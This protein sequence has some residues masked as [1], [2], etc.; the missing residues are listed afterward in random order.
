MGVHEGGT[1][2]LGGEVKE[3][4]RL[5]GRNGSRATE[6]AS[7]PVQQLCSCSSGK[8]IRVTSWFLALLCTGQR[9]QAA[10]WGRARGSQEVRAYRALE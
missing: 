7:R 10:G 1:W 5:G 6:A 9:Q 4:R 2:R 8:A 3:R